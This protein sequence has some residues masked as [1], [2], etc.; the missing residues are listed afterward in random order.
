MVLNT[1]IPYWF[2]IPL[3]ELFA[4][5][6]DVEKVLKEANKPKPGK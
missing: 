5:N 6:D 3:S 1:P 2:E 4:Y